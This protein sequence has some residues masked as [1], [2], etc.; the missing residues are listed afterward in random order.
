MARSYE[1]VIGLEVHAQLQ[2][3]QQALPQLLHGLRRGPNTRVCGVP[4]PPGALPVPND[5]PWSWPPSRGWRWAA[6]CAASRSTART[7]STRTS[8]RGYQISQFQHPLNLG[9]QLTFQVGRAEDG[10]LTRIHV[11]EDAA[12]NLHGAGGGSATVVDFNRAGTP[13]I[14][15]ERARAAQ[16]R[17]GRGACASCATCSCSWA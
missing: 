5:T 8:P 15:I 2:V 12:K 10:A 14:E 7:T 16:L 9:G 17:R 6:T 11:K 3:G 4:G 1:T 13:L